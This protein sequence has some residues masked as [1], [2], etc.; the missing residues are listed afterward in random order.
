MTWLLD[1]ITLRPTR[2]LIELEHGHRVTLQLDDRPLEFIVRHANSHLDG[3]PQLLVCKF[4]G[5]GG[6][7]ENFSI[8]PFD[9]WD[10]LSGM[11]CAVNPPGFGNSGGR[12]NL[13]SMVPAAQR[14]VEYLLAEYP[15]TPLILTGS[16]L[17]AAVALRVAAN[18]QVQGE[19]PL[20]G[21]ILRDPPQLY[22]VIM[23]RFAWWTGWLPTWAIARRSP[24]SF[25][26]H[27]AAASCTVP[28]LIVS[29]GADTIVP[30]NIQQQIIDRYAGP[31]RVLHL[32]NAN[33]S[34]P[35]TPD[36]VQ[37]YYEQLDW[38]ASH[39]YEE[40]RKS[41]RGEIGGIV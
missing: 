12:A 4:V 23:Q 7:A 6:R 30:P 27:T 32:P 5:A 28:A 36:E 14:A 10:H 40:G 39:F 20:Q 21:L 33:H 18:L 11:V 8:H 25:D 41:D 24:D 35:L 15:G 29:S 2:H 1:R 26:A 17:G 37:R 31:L 34:D 13:R 19:S 3:P 16:S 22:D 38:L 9:R